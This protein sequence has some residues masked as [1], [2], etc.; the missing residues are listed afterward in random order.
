M[1]TLFTQH[2][3]SLRRWVQGYGWIEVGRQPGSPALVRVLDEGGLIWESSSQEGS[4]DDALEA[5]EAAVVTWMD[6]ELAGR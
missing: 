4:I 2:Y 1:A 6:E 3:P 5:A